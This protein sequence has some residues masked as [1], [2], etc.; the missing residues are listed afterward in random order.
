MSL[1]V[2][3]REAAGPIRMPI[4]RVFSMKGFGTIATGTLVSGTIRED[5]ALELLPGSRPVKV[6]GLQVHGRQATFAEA[7][8]RVAV[9]LGGVD[10][11]D[12]V[13]GD[14]LCEPGSFEASRR[15]DVAL[16]LLPDVAPLRDGT[17]VRIHH[18]T[19]EVL[20]RVAT[21]GKF[22]RLRLESPAVVTRGDRIILRAYSPLATIGGAI[23]LDPHPP[24]GAMRSVAGRRRL[25]RLDIEA[26]PSDV[27]LEWFVEERGAAGL[28]KS[29][30]TRR[31]GLSAS[32]ASEASQRLAKGGGVALLGDVL[33]KP[34]VLTDL[35][36]RLIQELEAH[37]AAHPLSGGMPREE[38]RERV[39]RRAPQ[40]VFDHVLEMLVAERRV[41]ARDR[42][43]LQS[44]QV[45]LT[46]DE[47]RVQSALESL[48]REAALTPPDIA[49]AIDAVQASRPI[50]D[51]M[52][53]LLLRNRVL[54]KLDTIIFHSAALESLK[55]EVRAL[56]QTDS[57][58]R[59]D[60]ASFKTRYGIT[61][62]Y[63]IP[64][65][66]Y[67]DRERVTK[68]VGEARVVL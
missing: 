65:L 61:R 33:V 23:V 17:R 41:V 7:G 16:T 31:A 8:H 43:A 56:K 10:V 59:V 54:V 2:P 36:A 32:A 66:E 49:A 4:D 25:E 35:G 29:E 30:L 3:A 46:S 19:S 21:A 28:H 6:R 15:L 47:A 58:V 14:A 52:L 51:R 13:R 38:A 44:H 64:L 39:F 40:Q 55:A 18:G 62:K 27:T 50:A 45:S 57:A 26:N 24:R 22:A 1:A 34:K 5:E 48:Y 68:R 60:V 11:A 37:H 20:G 42:L 9:N 12:V 53:A 67:L 63:A